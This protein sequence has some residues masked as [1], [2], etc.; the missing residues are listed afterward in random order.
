MKKE[1][2]LIMIA[3]IIYI[4][5]FALWILVIMTDL[6]INPL[7]K[8]LSNIFW[9]LFIGL[10]VFLIIR[11]RKNII[12]DLKKVKIKTHLKITKNSLT[13][14]NLIRLIGFIGF[15]YLFIY[16]V[17]GGGG[18]AVVIWLIYGLWLIDKKKI[19]N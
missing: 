2:L 4:S 12:E 6:N 16:S 10:F 9:I 7:L 18:N 14:Y 17:Q 13:R 19:N 3:P 5:L 15:I 8:I 1:D 11:D